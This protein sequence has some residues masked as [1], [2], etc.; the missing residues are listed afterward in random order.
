MHFP[1]K[2]TTAPSLSWL[3]RH[4][5]SDLIT[6]SQSSRLFWLDNQDT[7]LL[8]WLPRHRNLQN[9]VRILDSSAPLPKQLATFVRPIIDDQGFLYL[10]PIYQHT[11]KVS[12]CTRKPQHQPREISLSFISSMEGQDIYLQSPPLSFHGLLFYQAPYKLTD[13]T[14]MKLSSKN[15]Y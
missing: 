10:P 13:F 6:K 9:S 15:F 3:P 5:T 4:D 1:C 2:D 14:T 11:H 7:S 12:S 8:S